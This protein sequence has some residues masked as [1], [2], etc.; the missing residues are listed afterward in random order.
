M[1]LRALDLFRGAKEELPANQVAEVYGCLDQAVRGRSGKVSRSCGAGYLSTSATLHSEHIPV[2][3][4]HRA[5][6]FHRNFR[7]R[8]RLRGTYGGI[9]RQP[10]DRGAVSYPLARAFATYPYDNQDYARGMPSGSYVLMLGR[11][12]LNNAACLLVPDRWGGRRFRNSGRRDLPV[13]WVCGLSTTLCHRTD[14]SKSV[15]RRAFLSISCRTIRMEFLDLS[16]VK[17]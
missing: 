1:T 10:H 7:R 17:V 9:V 13:F 12:R 5:P 8:Q 2:C 16:C 11:S 4:Q 6:D 15:D 3:A 14:A